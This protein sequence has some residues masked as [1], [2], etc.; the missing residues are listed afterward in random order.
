MENREAPQQHRKKRL[1]PLH[2]KRVIGRTDLDTFFSSVKS[3]ANYTCVQLF[4]S[5]ETKFLYPKFMRKE[6]HLHGAYQDFARNVGAPNI[7]LTD[8]AQT[9]IGLKWTT[10]SRNNATKQV[11]SVPHNQHQNQLERKVSDVNLTLRQS[12]APLIFWC[13]CLIFIVDCLNHTSVK[14]LDWRTPKEKQDSHTP[15][16][17][18]FRFKFWEPVWYYEPTAKYPA[19]N[20]LAGR[21]VGIAWD[22][23]DAFT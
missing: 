13:F 14:A 5:V 3:I 4:F 19:P 23:G 1:L 6:S 7:L 15:D 9:Q 17:S 18:S 12:N 22:H 21:F 20:F 11:N 16:I 2:P 8:N 10:T